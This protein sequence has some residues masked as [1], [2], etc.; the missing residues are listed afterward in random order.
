MLVAPSAEE[1]AWLDAE[2]DMSMESDADAASHPGWNEHPDPPGAPDPR[3]D[4][5][6]A[7]V[8]RLLGCHPQLT[9]EE[10]RWLYAQERSQC[11]QGGMGVG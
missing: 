11:A 2:F 7:Y 10:A 9:T 1:Q 5:E 4:T 3:E 6:E 8:S